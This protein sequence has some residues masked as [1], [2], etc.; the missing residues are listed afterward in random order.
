MGDSD[1]RSYPYPKHV[2]AV[3]FI[4]IIGMNLWLRMLPLCGY[5]ALFKPDMK[6]C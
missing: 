6:C 5:I 1:S 3:G 4:K 2:R